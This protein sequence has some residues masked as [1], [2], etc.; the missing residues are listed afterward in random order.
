MARK[1]IPVDDLK[2]WTN[3]FNTNPSTTPQER[4]A[5]NWMMERVLHDTGNYKGFQW[6]LPGGLRV[7]T[8][9]IMDNKYDDSRRRYY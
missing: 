6:I 9:D 4:I 7:P 2:T 3:D 8:G 1:T 5:I